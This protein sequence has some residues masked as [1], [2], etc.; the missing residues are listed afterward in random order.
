MKPTHQIP[1]PSF[2]R[3]LHR[4]QETEHLQKGDASRDDQLFTLS[5]STSFDARDPSTHSSKPTTT[6]SQTNNRDI[7]LV[8][9]LVVG[10]LQEPLQLLDG[11]LPPG[12]DESCFGVAEIVGSS[13]R[14]CPLDFGVETSI[15][16]LRLEKIV[17]E[18]EAREGKEERGELELELTKEAA[19]SSAL[20]RRGN[21]K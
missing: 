7:P 3:S 16:E 2:L 9:L 15:C 17:F 8:D 6:P 13:Q 21:G 1:H 10:E 11:L 4:A 20:K 5:C 19:C 18:G 14:S 12:F